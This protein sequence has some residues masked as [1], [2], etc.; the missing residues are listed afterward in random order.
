MC[1]PEWVQFNLRGVKTRALVF[2][3]VILKVRYERMDEI[4]VIVVYGVLP[5]SDNRALGALF[6]GW[7]HLKSCKTCS[8]ARF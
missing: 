4:T 8:V 7:F 5:N 3:H 6:R 2:F 1:S